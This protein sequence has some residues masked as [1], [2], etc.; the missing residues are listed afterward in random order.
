MVLKLKIGPKYFFYLVAIFLLLRLII[1]SP[2]NQKMITQDISVAESHFITIRFYFYLFWTGLFLTLY[3]HIEK[4][5]SKYFYSF[6]VW[7]IIFFL[8]SLNANIGFDITDEGWQLA[9]SWGLLS[10][11]ISNNSDLIWGSSFVSGLWLKIFGTPS[12]IWSRFGYILFI[13]F[14]GIVIYNILIKYL[15]PRKAFFGIIIS[16]LIFYR[17][18]LIFP[19]M[20]YYNLPLFLSLLSILF[21]IKNIKAVNKKERM[22]T[23]LILSAVFAGVAVHLKFTFIIIIFFPPVFF[24]ISRETYNAK[25]YLVYYLTFFSSIILGFMLIH[26]LGG[27][28]DLVYDHNRLSVFDMFSTF[29]GSSETDATLNYSAGYL[30]DLYFGQFL[31]TLRETYLVLII[32]LPIT[33]LSR[34]TN[35]FNYLFVCFLGL[36]M[37]LH[38]KHNYSMSYLKLMCIFFSMSIIIFYANRN[39]YKDTVLLHMIFLS[40]F[41]LSFAGSGTSFYGGFFSLGFW[42]YSAYVLTIIFSSN[43]SL[44]AS[45]VI[46]YSLICFIMFLQ[47]FNTYSP[48]RDLPASYLNTMFSSKELFGIYSFK[49]RVDVVDELI[50][51]SKKKITASDRIIFVTLPMF[52]YILDIKPIISETT[53]TLLSFEQLKKEVINANPNIIVVPVQ[54]PRGYLWPLPQNADHWTKDGF[55]RQTAHYYKFYNE[56]MTQN[57]FE[58]I[59]ENKMFIV[60]RKSDMLREELQP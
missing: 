60:Y 36:F 18:Y 27:S 58:R 54:S 34:K 32:I 47:V 40:V 13:P 55:E 59:F 19:S 28:R 24:L 1:L 3:H 21:L 33:Y 42:G 15:E 26:I 52:Y 6:L 57:N 23:Y 46:Q 44:F 2:T 25:D 37:Y 30:I 29:F 39:D 38:F 10:G 20:N 5:G 16:F 45:K 56:Y 35:K 14:I 4:K 7:N 53:E 50:D 22:I 31:F 43:D 51:F 9:K 49:E 48:Y 11:D 12:L 8:L 17:N 41:V